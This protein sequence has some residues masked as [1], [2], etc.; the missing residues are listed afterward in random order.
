M[1]PL[2]RDGIPKL[3]LPNSPGH[4]PLV[5][6]QRILGHL[7]QPD[8]LIHI[9]LLNCVH[10]SQPCLQGRKSEGDR[11][12]KWPGQV[13]TLFSHCH[14]S[15]TRNRKGRLRPP[16]NIAVW[17]RHCQTETSAMPRAAA[18]N[19]PSLR[20]STLASPGVTGPGETRLFSVPLGAPRQE[21]GCPGRLWLCPWGS[22][23]A[24]SAVGQ[25]ITLPART[26]LWSPRDC[27]QVQNVQV[28][29]EGVGVGCALPGQQV[30]T[31]R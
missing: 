19:C 18:S 21:P 30:P 29:V 23:S 1:L 22:G 4:L 26:A 25:A 20:L 14:M 7:H 6:Q 13:L 8:G 12:E 15:L 9:F 28:A 16:P 17:G 31:V 24:G 10:H 3:P 2:I 5:T 11:K 27:G